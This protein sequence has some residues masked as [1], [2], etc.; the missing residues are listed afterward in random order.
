[1]HDALILEVAHDEWGE[2]LQLA[3]QIMT[4][5]VPERLMTRTDPPLR[6]TAEPD[7]DD[8]PHKWGGEQWHPSKQS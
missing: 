1:M 3:S 7:L 6:W 5:V 2:A 4:S 8:N